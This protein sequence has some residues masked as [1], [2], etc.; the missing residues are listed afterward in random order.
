MAMAAAPRADALAEVAGR[1]GLPPEGAL[2]EY[3]APDIAAIDPETAASVRL[4]A[5]RAACVIVGPAMQQ[6][7]LQRGACIVAADPYLYFARVSQLL[8]PVHIPDP[9][10]H[11]SAVISPT[12]K[13][14]R[15]A[16]CP[17][18]SG[19]KYKKCHGA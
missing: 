4:A 8:N 11:P 5:S 14:G 18:G 17:C 2:P 16:L 15:N 12:A 1:L 10:I 9:P 6:V 13:I 3:A 19:K 7:A